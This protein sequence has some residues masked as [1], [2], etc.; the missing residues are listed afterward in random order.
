MKRIRFLLCLLTALC[1]LL[2]FVPAAL[3]EEPAPSE[4][5]DRF[6][7]KT[8]DELVE[9]LLEKWGT[10]SEH[11][12]LAYY[13]TVTGEEHYVNPDK[14]MITASM[15]KVPLNMLF[16]ERISDG[17][18]Q[19]DSLIAG[20]RYENLLENSIVHS[21]NECAEIL[22]KQFPSYHRYRELIAPYMGE[23]PE[24][25]DDKY[26]ENNFFTARQMLHCLKVLYENQDRYPRLI[27]SMQR[28]QPDK[29]FKRDER[30]FDIAHKYGYLIEGYTLNMNDCAICFTDDPILIVMFTSGCAKAYEIMAEY[31]TLMC[32]YTQY[33]TAIRVAEE[34]A[35]AERQ[36]ELS[37]EAAEKAAEEAERIR[38]ENPNA[39]LDPGAV[40]ELQ[41]AQGFFPR[42]LHLAEQNGLSRSTLI[43]AG[44][45]I[46]V[47]LI[48]CLVLAS[49]GLR[50]RV[51]SRFAVLAAVL[52]CLA[53]L[54]R[55]AY[56]ALR[57]L[58]TGPT[59]D[60]VDTVQ[61][62]LDALEQQDQD[63]L[64]ACLDGVVALGLDRESES[65]TNR[66][67]WAAMNEQLSGELS[68]EVQRDGAL[69][70][71]QVRFQ[72]FDLSALA[73]DARTEA[74]IYV[75]QFAATHPVSQLYDE[76][77]SYRADLLRENWDKA[78]DVMLLHP[79]N[80]IRSVSMQ[81]ELRW[82]DGAWHIVPDGRLLSLMTGGV[83]LSG[84]EEQA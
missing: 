70:Y 26:Y 24:T 4:E 5:E 55:M 56:P 57:Q 80:Y 62:F 83:D 11:V 9:E 42:L 2:S 58:Q 22:W 78:V 67:I 37:R 25:V 44:A 45:A 33:H 21:S 77:G 23:D 47:T 60:P 20:V 39:T 63:R 73:W 84:E 17:E 71:Q 31:P 74:M 52:L 68:G 1:L 48:L 14:Y 49:L 81:L 53:A 34:K 54:L 15:Y 65:E 69:A 27:E 35:E 40:V 79:E 43:A 16:L 13:N 82:H 6:A 8:W 66:A 19:W 50:F 18:L 51:R 30:R 32:D 75:S 36:A 29:Y 76:S 46:L 10:D 59:K 7:D 72:Y 12:T 3:A 38:E 61:D 28:A 64:C 41:E